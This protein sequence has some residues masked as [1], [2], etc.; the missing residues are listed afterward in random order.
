MHLSYRDVKN[1]SQLACRRLVAP[2]QYIRL[3]PQVNDPEVTFEQ[4]LETLQIKSQKSEWAK[5]RNNDNTFLC[6]FFILFSPTG[7]AFTISVTS[8]SFIKHPVVIC[9]FTN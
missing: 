9:C 5:R 7:N 2:T 6:R 8:D 4:D 1:C 3:Y